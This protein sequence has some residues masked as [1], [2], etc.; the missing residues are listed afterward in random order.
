MKLVFDHGA[1][2]VEGNI[3]APTNFRFNIC[4]AT[5]DGPHPQNGSNTRSPSLEDA[6]MMRRNNA[7][8]FCVAKP[9][10]SL[11]PEFGEFI[12]FSCT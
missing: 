12:P 4:A 5:N 11:D 10:R 3:N 6:S 2:G 7:K 1:Y 9:N 8:G